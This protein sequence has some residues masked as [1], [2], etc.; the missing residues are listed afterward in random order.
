MAERG[1]NRKQ[2]QVQCSQELGVSNGLGGFIDGGNWEGATPSFV[3]Q[4]ENRRHTHFFQQRKFFL[5]E[6]YILF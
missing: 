3:V 2:A 4:P 5:T 1:Y 6:F